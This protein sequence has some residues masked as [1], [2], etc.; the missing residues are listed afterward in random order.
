MCPI[1]S[2]PGAIFDPPG[3]FGNVWRHWH[4]VGRGQGMLQ[5]CAAYRAAPVTKD[6]SGQI[7]K[8]TQGEKLWVVFQRW[9][10]KRKHP[11]TVFPVNYTATTGDI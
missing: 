1:G 9:T 8:S 3:A 2:Q 11:K 7:V 4:L 10:E 6:S 5:T